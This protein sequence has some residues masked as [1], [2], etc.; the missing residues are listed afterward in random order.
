MFEFDATLPL[1]AIQFLLL[2][3]IMNAVFY[4]PLTKAI[5]DR[6]DFIRSTNA[7]AQE[8]LAKAKLM[9]EKY[10]QELM[11]TRR[12]AQAAIAAAQAEAKQIAA[13]QI[14]QAQRQV[15]AQLQQVQQELEQQRQ[16]AFGALEQQIGIL[17]QQILEKLIGA[18]VG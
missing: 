7:E 6:S 2:V 14:A 3:V 11:A 10:E 15:Q 4:K 16:T 13:D 8:R 17:S 18:S 5:D 9:A 12:Q 1:M